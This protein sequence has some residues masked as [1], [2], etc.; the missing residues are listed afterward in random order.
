MTMMKDVYWCISVTLSCSRI[1]KNAML[2]N[3]L[4][5]HTQ[6][7]LNKWINLVASCQCILAWTFKFTDYNNTFMSRDNI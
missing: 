2:S 6:N 4:T 5:M 3:N 1:Q 7:V